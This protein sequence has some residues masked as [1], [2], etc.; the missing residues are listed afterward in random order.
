M[1]DHRTDLQ[2]EVVFEDGTMKRL[3]PAD[4]EVV[5]K[6][7]GRRCRLVPGGTA[8]EMPL[9][10]Q[11]EDDSIE[12]LATRDLEKVLVQASPTGP[13]AP[14][15]GNR[16]RLTGGDQITVRFA[17][18]LSNML[19]N[20]S[21]IA[22]EQEETP[23]WHGNFNGLIPIDEQGGVIQW[24]MNSRVNYQHLVQGKPFCIEA[25]LADEAMLGEG[26]FGQVWR[27]KLEESDHVFAVKTVSPGNCRMPLDIAESMAKRE[28]EI[29]KRL[30]AHPHP[31][32]ARLWD[33]KC[34]GQGAEATYCFVMELCGGGKL[35]DRIH[36]AM[37]ESRA[38][39]SPYAA[40]SQWDRWAVQIFFALEHLH[41]RTNTLSRDLKP[42]NVVIADSGQAKLVDFGVGQL[43][44]HENVHG[45][46]FKMPPGTPGYIAPEVFLRNGQN[47][48]S[49]LY[50][51]GVLLWVLLTGGINGQPP[52]H[53]H[54][55]VGDNYDCLEED[56][57]G[58]RSMIDQNEPQ[59]V[60]APYRELILSLTKYEAAERPVHRDVL[61][62]FPEE[63][64]EL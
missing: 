46:S 39:Q 48:Q 52:N 12:R 26:T 45:W 55:L 51:F 14:S 54:M 10:V 27:A 21:S 49:D 35:A 64:R 50:S 41:F 22:D 13:A 32:I 20:K 24:W 8:E 38:A 63:L 15:S 17:R 1:H 47:A 37:E 40:P 36:R 56:W 29:S 53:M 11:F 61:L 43:S 30:Q 25:S 9:E 34:F 42:D 6:S 58:L 62:T 57:M 44:I 3:L 31:C 23:G 16:T 19:S 59:A 60:Q 2:F 33:A 18:Q 7:S 28:L 4:L 5:E